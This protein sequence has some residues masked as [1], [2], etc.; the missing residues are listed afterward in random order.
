M[1]ARHAMK[2]LTDNLTSLKLV[3]FCYFQS[4]SHGYFRA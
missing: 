3:R 2:A 1:G 4:S